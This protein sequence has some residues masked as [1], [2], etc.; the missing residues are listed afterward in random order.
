MMKY[1]I[2]TPYQKVDLF[3]TT[4]L[5]FVIFLIV[6]PMI[7]G[8]PIN[9]QMIG[10]MTILFFVWYGMTFIMTNSLVISNQKLTNKS[11]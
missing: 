2:L 6:R 5:F 1:Y 9:G 11:L 3:V 7:L 4:L 10:N 8:E